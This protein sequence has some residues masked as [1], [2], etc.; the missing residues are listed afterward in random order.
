MDF[1]SDSTPDNVHVLKR[2]R[3]HYWCSRWKAR[4]DKAFL[5]LVDQK[6]LAGQW[7]WRGVKFLDAPWDRPAGFRPPFNLSQAAAL[8]QDGPRLV[9]GLEICQI[10]HCDCGCSGTGVK[11]PRRLYTLISPMPGFKTSP[12]KQPQ[13]AC[14]KFPVSKRIQ[15]VFFF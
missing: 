13:S 11:A 4:R 5:T 14:P 12:A 3:K 15:L 10:Q 6:P 2:Y 7:F 1:N 9:V 8:A